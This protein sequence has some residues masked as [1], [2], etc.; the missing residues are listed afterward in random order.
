MVSPDAN[1]ELSADNLPPIAGY[2]HLLLQ[3]EIQISVVTEYARAAKAEGVTVVL[4][5]APA[6]SLHPEL[7]AAIDLSIVNE[8]ELAAIAGHDSN[9]ANCLECIEVLCVVVTFGSRGCYGQEGDNIIAQSDFSV[10]AI[11]ATTAGDTV[12]GVL[13]AALAHGLMPQQA[14]RRACAAGALACAKR[15]AQGSIPSGAKIDSVLQ[16]NHFP[17]ASQTNCLRKYCGYSVY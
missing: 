5:A 16:K 9:I 2:S 1:I 3:L 14:L 11:G 12:C 10:R 7:L 6:K 13:V 15:G 4:N 17:S 8:G